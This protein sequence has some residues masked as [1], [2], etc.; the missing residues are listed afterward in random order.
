MK[1]DDLTTCNIKINQFPYKSEVSED[2]SPIDITEEGDCDSYATAKQWRL[3]HG[4]GWPVEALRLACCFVE[5]SAAPEKRNLYHCVL[6]ADFGDQTYVL[7]N[8]HPYPMEYQLLNYEW[9][10]YW[11]HEMNAWEWAKGADKSF[12]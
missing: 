12:A 7:D 9:H 6:L 2:W 3:V 1:L 4:Y 5:P 11:N 8:R 10:K